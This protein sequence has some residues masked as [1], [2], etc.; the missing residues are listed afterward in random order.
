MKSRMVEVAGPHLHRQAA[1]FPCCQNAPAALSYNIDGLSIYNS[2]RIIR[3]SKLTESEI[4]ARIDAD[5]VS[6]VF[7][8]NIKQI[9]NIVHSNVCVIPIQTQAKQVNF[10]AGVMASCFK[11]F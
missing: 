11:N 3:N 7:S 2:S 8:V 4:F 6:K 5:L 9:N 10:A 1:V